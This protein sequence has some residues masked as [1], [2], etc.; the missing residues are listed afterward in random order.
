MKCFSL[1]G[2]RLLWVN[3]RYK[4]QVVLILAIMAQMAA[5]NGCSKRSEPAAEP[6]GG[7]T[8]TVAAA[9]VASPASTPAADPE[10]AGLP[11]MLPGAE[12]A[13]PSWVDGQQDEPFPVR[14]FW[15]SRALPQ[16]NA[17]PLYFA[18]MAEIAPEMYLDSPPPGWP[19][20]RSALPEQV[21]RLSDAVV[22]LSDNEKLKQ[23]QVPAAEI[24]NCLTLARTAIEKLDAAQRRPQCVFFIKMRF[25]SA[26]QHI[27][28]A[29]AFVRLAS[30]QLC[31]AR[32]QGNFNEAEEAA[33]RT[34]RLAR[35]LRV[36][37]PMIAQLVSCTIDGIVYQDIADFT[38]TQPNLTA[39]DCDRLLAL[40]TEHQR[41]GVSQID[42]GLRVEYLILRN[43]LD[44]LQHG[45]L[46]HK[47][48]A[49]MIALGM[50]ADSGG[51]RPQDI[52]QQLAAANWPVEIAACNA[53]YAAAISL[54]AAPLHQFQTDK[55]TGEVIPKIRAQNA[56]IT[57]L[58]LPVLD[59][60]VEAM[61]R[62]HTHLAAVQCLTAVRRYALAHGSLPVD[63]AVACREAGMQSVPTD[64]YSGNAM[65]Y[66]IID[67]KPIV[68]SVGKD[69]KDDGG[70]MDWNYG[71]TLGDFIFRMRE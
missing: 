58:L 71:R 56:R 65:L 9:P 12:V 24:E 67:G 31:H 60:F 33:K 30:V 66:K 62:D 15:E 50:Y 45:R 37:G 8:S 54:A 51:P 63:L 23:Q 49:E 4:A 46:P 34:L 64:P 26:F 28:V 3:G 6:G 7:A 68:Y 38:L 11:Q 39:Q 5:G 40:L 27:Q 53:A 14:K 48:A 18:A 42:E 57:L 69:R 22:A 70:E 52:E 61:K 59:A 17:A 41:D 16:R 55:W 20:D 10:T 44:D 36:F 32:M 2:R 19:W 21:K 1:G 13:V 35:D 47:Q 25:D 29:R 43:T